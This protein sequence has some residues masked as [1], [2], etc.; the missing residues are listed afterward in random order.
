V[1]DWPDSVNTQPEDAMSETATKLLEQLLALPESE[2]LLIAD[3][4]WL[5]AREEKQ[6]ELIDEATSDPEF[7]AELDR[8]LKEVEEHPERLLDGQAVMDELREHLRRK[9]GQ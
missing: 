4:L 8:R 7:Q 2:R 5:S 6:Q 9:N 3:Q 1:V